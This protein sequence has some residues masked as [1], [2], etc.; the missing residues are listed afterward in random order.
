[1]RGRPR[2][3]V[4]RALVV[5]A[6]AWVTWQFVVP[7][8]TEAV[9]DQK[10]EDLNDFARIC[11]N[12]QRYEDSDDPFEK[13][14]PYEGN[15]P[16]PWVLIEDGYQEAA[17][18]GARLDTGPEPEPSEVQLVMCSDRFGHLDGGTSC[19]YVGSEGTTSLNYHAGRYS[20]TVYEARTGR[21]VDGN[22]LSG[23]E[24]GECP[25]YVSEYEDVLYTEPGNA[26][27]EALMADVVT[28]SEA[29]APPPE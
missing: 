11:E 14:A 5:G 27:Y 26:D 23:A 20:V 2:K 4:V 3:I 7:P 16:H 25:H 10:P 12:A 1:M 24:P 17:S 19:G 18:T 28:G 15:G 13:A 21:R 29:P 6:L 22:V 9:L 8:L